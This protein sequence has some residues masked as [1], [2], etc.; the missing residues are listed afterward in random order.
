[1]VDRRKGLKASG[2]EGNAAGA[3]AAPTDPFA[4]SAA[5]TVSVLFS[6]SRFSSSLLKASLLQLAEIYILSYMIAVF[7][8]KKNQRTSQQRKTFTKSCL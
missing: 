6:E 2:L 5:E 1:M 3:V 4:E 8:E 7:R